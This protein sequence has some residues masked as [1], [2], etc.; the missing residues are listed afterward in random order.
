MGLWTI[1]NVIQ[2]ERER[3]AIRRHERRQWAITITEILILAGLI[4]GAVWLIRWL[5]IV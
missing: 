2:Q 4:A 5:G 3:K 1:D